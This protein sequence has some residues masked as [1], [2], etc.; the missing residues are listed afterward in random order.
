VKA[1]REAFFPPLLAEKI[2]ER[3]NELGFRSISEYVVSVMR[4]DQLLGGKHRLFSGNDFR[5]EILAA[6]DRETLS[7]LQT[8]D[9]DELPAR[10]SR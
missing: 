3:W 9:P 7:E 10:T 1:R 2:E 6:L 8:E 5:P 4:Y